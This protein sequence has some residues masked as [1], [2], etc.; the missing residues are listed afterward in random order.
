MVPLIGSS[1]ETLVSIN[2][3]LC[4]ALIDTGS[5]VTAMSETYYQ[6][7]DPRPK[8]ENL[9]DFTVD[10]T[11]AN[12]G[13]VP[14]S[15]YV[16]LDIQIPSSDFPAVCVPVMVCE[17]T[18][19]SSTVPVTIGTNVLNHFRMA[20]DSDPPEVWQQAF[21]ALSYSHTV[22]VK[23]FCHRKVVVQPFSTQTITGMVRKVGEMSV[24]VT[25]GLE[26]NQH[27][28]ICPRVVNVR[29]GNNFSRIPVR[30]CNMTA[31][32]INILP[33]SLLCNLQEIEV[34][35]KID[36]YE[37][38]GQNPVKVE[39][40]LEDLEITVPQDNL[41]PA[42]QG[43]V[44]DFLGQWKHI[45]SKDP[46]DLGC[47]NLVE[48]EIE[49]EDPTPFKQPYRRI[50]PGMFEEVREHLKEMLDAGAIRE[51]HSPFSSNIVLVRK[52]DNSLR[53]CIDYRKLNNRT[54]KDAYS[55]PRIDETMDTL[56]GSKYFSKLDLRS[57][58]WQ[59]PMREEDKA[60][61]AFSVGPLGFF[62]CNR[63]AFGLCNA[64][65]TFQRLM[66]RCMGELHLKECVIYLDDIIIYSETLPEHFS[67]LEAVFQRLEAA[68]LKLKGK[69][70]EFLKTRVEYLGHI[71]S[72]AGIE[73]NPE[74]VRTIQ[75]TEVPT[76]LSKLR[77]FLGFA[78]YYRRFVPNFAH[79]A[80]PLND[81][82]VGHPTNQKG[83]SK[84]AAAPWKWGKV[85]QQAFDELKEVLISPPVLAYADYDKP[86]ILNV[87]ASCTGLGAVLY[88]EHDGKERVV[89]Y[90]SR[91]LRRGERNYPAHKLEFL[92]L[93]WAVVDKFHD[94]LYG[95]RPFHVR[96]DNNPLTYA[97]TTA[98]LDA[99]SHR[100]LAALA[101]YNFTIC[102]RSGIQN[103]DA[104]FLSRKESDSSDLEEDIPSAD[105]EEVI[106]FPDTLKALF[107]AS[108]LS[109]E[110]VPAFEC[111]ALAQHVEVTEIDNGDPDTPLSE[112]DWRVEQGKD[113]TV[114]KVIELLGAGHKLTNRQSALQPEAVRKLLRE[115]DR[116][117]LQDNLLYRAGTVSGN[118]VD[119]LVLPEAFQD[120]VFMGLHDDAGHQ[121]RER[122]IALVKSRFYWPGMDFYI[123]KRVGQ[124]PRCIRRKRK[125]FRATGLV[126][127]TSTYPLE[128][129]CMDF[130]SLEMSSGGFEHILVITDHF[131]R[132]AQAY[133]T[134]N[135]TATTTAKCLFDNFIVHYG[136]PSRL[137]SDRGRN[138][139]SSVIAE[140]C[141]IANVD[142][143][144]TTPY[145]PQ[146][147]GQTE[148][149]NQT[150][151]NMLGTLEEDKKVEWKKHVPTMV[152]AYNSTR[153]ESTGLT[154]HF[155][156][157]GRHPRLALDA[158]LGIEP[159]RRPGSTD[160]QGYVSSLRKRLDFAY[161]VAGRE[162]KR[163]GRRH[164]RHYDK[165]VR[166][167]R[168]EP[169]DRVLIRKVGL[170]GKNKLADRWDKDI[171]VVVRQ[172]NLDS[173]VY[174]VKK[175]HGRDVVKTLHRNLLLPFM[176]L[177]LC[178]PKDG[179]EANQQQE[180]DNPLSRSVWSSAPVGPDQSPLSGSLDSVVDD[181]VVSPVESVPVSSPVL[182]LPSVGPSA[183]SSS[184]LESGQPRSEHVPQCETGLSTSPK[185]TPATAVEASRA[186]VGK[187][188][189]AKYV[190]PARRLDPL[191]PVFTPTPTPR[192]KRNR[193]LPW[194]LNPR[195]WDVG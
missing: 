104:D 125:E 166:N 95:G 105:T 28:N 156:M 176:G 134:R 26:Q 191:A 194:R 18:S 101:T 175:E 89:A 186:E 121:G 71:V 189:T 27:M 159:D 170:K 163:Q 60:K 114:A 181:L 122:T 174:E 74:K 53:F 130:L 1:N 59:V 51:S 144:R 137:H 111:V 102:Y 184:T 127:I 118:P 133:P 45:F 123:E 193:Q 150:L 80:K 177:P 24:G 6:S 21:S 17:D 33:K 182:T 110:E 179:E 88:Q 142:K 140:L 64:P 79:I 62:E 120:V 115:W 23:A 40:S 158:F 157:F 124:C 5:M 30:I 128:L 90:A 61:T 187:T 76:T 152:H 94:Y 48:H 75:T 148:R 73:A 96:T 58:Y 119:Q 143:S 136:F 129:V 83:K 99:T 155:L 56:K 68:N 188:V 11:S 185:A 15:G 34:V 3:Q 72:E 43:E 190:I 47:T 108:S 12:G 44:K 93:K 154:P 36:P 66:E 65:G 167:V 132:Y 78:S 178:T 37:G 10:I 160:K 46:T 138:F 2:G 57:G 100:W 41:S 139:E 112:V 113:P 67:R 172:S 195:H 9:V 106:I 7:M 149:F 29:P 107:Q 183:I 85:E 39:P 146:G 16:L 14:Y 145:H 91:G 162:A 20:S 25:E 55:L 84:R 86:F 54:I 42:Q 31:R 173:P 131:T 82:L 117:K 116:L 103:I 49:L 169:G 171:Y 141:R 161:K 32:P 180:D 87:D 109:I 168:I 81:L 126:P 13:T 35:R 63:M 4:T 151:L 147:N 92:A 153:H 22:P 19:Y 69:K 164:K 77:S 50:P 98:K 38:N 70:C 8:L 165:K 135:Q 97:F 192:P 52:K